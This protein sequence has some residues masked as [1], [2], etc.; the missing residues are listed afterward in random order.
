MINLA[1]HRDADRIVEEELFVAGI[2][3]VRVQPYGEAHTIW[4]GRLGPY[5]FR[6]S[7]YY[8]VVEGPV[9]LEAARAIYKQ[10]PYG[11]RD[12]RVGG[13]CGCPAPEDSHLSYRTADGKRIHWLRSESDLYLYAKFKNGTLGESMANVLGPL[14]R[15]E[16]GP[17][18]FTVEERDA[19][20]ASIT[21]D[22]YHID[23][24]AGLKVFV[25]A[26]TR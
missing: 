11:R 12:V 1:G 13:D 21:V 10:R 18:V 7:W 6:R 22:L 4:A 26:V 20:T 25:E 3:P 24:Q 17:L 23:S 15:G 16:E 9:P 8:W 2:E 14:F 19:I 5:T